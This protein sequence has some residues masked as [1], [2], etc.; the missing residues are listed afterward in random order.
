MPVQKTDRSTT[1]MIDQSNE[2]WT[3]TR[4]ARI[5]VN[6]SNGIDELGNSGNEIK[7]LGDIIVK[8]FDF[9]GV[10]VTGSDSAVSIGKEGSINARQGSYGILSEGA[11]SDIVN[12]GLIR[13]GLEGIHGE[14]WNDVRNYGTIRADVGMNFF[15]EGSQI[16]NYGLVDVG[17]VGIRTQAEGTHIENAKGGVFRSDNIAIY[18]SG[19]GT[20]ELINKGTISGE[21]FAITGDGLFTVINTGKIVGDVTMGSD[22][23]VFD[24]RNGE[25]KGTVFGEDGDDDYYVSQTSLKISEADDL[26]SGYDEVRST[27]SYK[28]SANIESLELL[29][30]KDL[31]GTGGGT[32]NLIFGNSGDNRLSGLGGQDNLRGFGGNDILKGGAGEDI[33][34]FE[35]TNGGVDRVTDFVDGLDRI[36]IDTIDS[37]QEFDALDIKQLKSG[38]LLINLGGGDKIIIE[39]LVMANFTYLEDIVV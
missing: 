27:V 37:Q 16:Y 31:D 8:G 26:D 14:M 18:V 3:L 34:S 19:P 22:N 12:R 35:L 23:S 6:D 20:S 13:A 11:G 33:F 10:I 25:L 36:F 32:D 4:N 38:D 21:N 15:G 24:C 1:W 7:V 17:N 30:K 29:G 9:S 28:L 39:D 2:T 5:T